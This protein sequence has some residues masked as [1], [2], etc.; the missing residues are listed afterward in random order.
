M[1][2]TVALQLL[3]LADVKM[4]F[5]INCPLT[6]HKSVLNLCRPCS[7]GSVQFFSIALYSRSHSPFIASSVSCCLIFS[8]CPFAWQFTCLIYL[9]CCFSSCF[10]ITDAI[11]IDTTRH[12]FSL[13]VPYIYFLAYSVICIAIGRIKN[14]EK[15]IHKKRTRKDIKQN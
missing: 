14:T 1:Q 13:C 12:I 7:S 11:R 8:F 10:H 15:H 2:L 4:A 6:V 5:K 3:H 9:Q